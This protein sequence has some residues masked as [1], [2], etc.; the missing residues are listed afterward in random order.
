MIVLLSNLVKNEDFSRHSD[1]YKLFNLREINN[2]L[3]IIFQDIEHYVSFSTFYFQLFFV[4][5]IPFS[6]TWLIGK[7]SLGT[8]S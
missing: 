7:V 1:T 4:E 6:N 3:I 5:Y 2:Y 8:P